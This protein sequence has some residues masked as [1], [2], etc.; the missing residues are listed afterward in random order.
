M[1]R[2]VQEYYD[3]MFKEK[4]LF[5]YKSLSEKQRRHFLGMEYERLGVGSGVYL[6][7]V[8]SCNRRRIMTGKAELSKAQESNELIDYVRQRKAGGGAK[9]KNIQHLLP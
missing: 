9:K 8:F 6:S 4:Q 3:S 7:K 2:K 5:Y 1:R